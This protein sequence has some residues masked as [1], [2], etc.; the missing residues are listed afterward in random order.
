LPPRELATSPGISSS[1]VDWPRP[2]TPERPYRARTIEPDRHPLILDGLAVT[3][4]L[5]FKEPALRV[6][7]CRAL[8]PSTGEPFKHTEAF[9]I[10]S[11]PNFGQPGKACLG[12]RR[13]PPAVA[14]DVA[15]SSRS[16][17]SRSSRATDDAR[18]QAFLPLVEPGGLSGGKVG[19]R[20]SLWTG[21]RLSAAPRARHLAASLTN[22]RTA[23]RGVNRKT[24]KI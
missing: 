3:F 21:R 19:M 17:N 22:I 1:W 6:R 14:P 15:T 2:T 23:N 24:P 12:A 18:P 9:R 8:Q 7:R 16:L 10:Q 5:V 4:Y 20:A 13:L 11:S